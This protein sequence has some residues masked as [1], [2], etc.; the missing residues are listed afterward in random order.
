[1]PVSENLPKGPLAIQ[2]Q[3]VGILREAGIDGYCVPDPGYDGA[4]YGSVRIRNAHLNGSPFGMK[5]VVRILNPSAE[6]GE[7]EGEVIEVLGDPGR[8]DVLML[9]ILRQYGL[10]T[11][12]PAAVVEAASELPLD[13]SPEEIEREIQSGRKDRRSLRTITVDGEDAKDLDDAI[14]IEKIPGKGYRL[15]VHIADVSHYVTD[16]SAL[17]IEARNRATSVYLTD[18]VIPMLPPKLSNG[19]CSLNPNRPRLTLTAEMRVGFDGE[20][21]GGKVYESIIESDA[22]TSYKEVYGVLFENQYLDRYESFVPMFQL[23]RELKDVL[24]A[25]RLRRGA[26]EFDFPETH[27]DLDPNGKPLSI[28]AYPINYANG[29]IEEF[30]ILANEFVATKF[31]G[32]K[33][34]FVYRVHEEPDPMKIRDF[35]SVAKLFGAH[36]GHGKATPGFLS[37]LMREIEGETYAPA[38]SQLLL[39]SL[40]KA[41]YS[42]ENL[43]HFG[44]ASAGYCH[45]TSPIRRYPDLYIHRI[46]KSYLRDEDKRAYF[47]GEVDDVSEHSSAMERNSMDAERASVNQMAAEYMTEHVGEDY[48][49]I[50][51]GIFSGG[52]FVRLANTV[53]GMVPFRTMDDYYEFDERRLEARGKMSGRVFCIGQPVRV[54][55]TGADIYL[56]RIDFALANRDENKKTRGKASVDA[57]PRNDL[58]RV[59]NGNRS[60]FGV[61]KGT[62]KKSSKSALSKRARPHKKR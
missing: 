21:T 59:E 23:M 34:P 5:V 18:R 1:M 44:L 57:A 33:Y 36:T 17:D 58:N 25:K 10:S 62:S 51:S 47:A 15:Y 22:R 29:I 19:L 55:V 16:R 31:A 11:E 30:M 38:L 49:G 41:R 61:K 20:V 8:T 6:P 46:I 14:S 13:P 4:Q 39:R 26:I 24:T 43:G 32:L 54:T 50:L 37:D 7:Y 2:N 60:E 52:I 40:A 35:L 53:E 56:R 27:V 48:E 12:F 42:P 9:S 45:F 28:Y 3:C